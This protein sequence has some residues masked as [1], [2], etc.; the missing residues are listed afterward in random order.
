VGIVITEEFDP[1]GVAI[2]SAA[3][4][5]VIRD[6][7]HATPTR[8]TASGPGQPQSEVSVLL[9]QRSL[10][11]SFVPGAFV[12][13]GGAIDPADN[14]LASK[15][16]PNH[17]PTPAPNGLE[18][19]L[20][21]RAAKIASLRECFEEAGLLPGCH[22]NGTPLGAIPEKLRSQRKHVHAGVTPFSVALASAAIV[23]NLD[24]MIPFGRWVTPAGP[25]RR[26]DTRFFLVGAAEEQEA[27]EDGS[28]LVASQWMTPSSALAAA[29]A[30]ELLLIFPTRKTLERLRGVS[31][32]A[33]CLRNEGIASI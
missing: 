15:L 24:A 5:V 10:T 3:T 12:F 7:P 32:F 31:S 20:E 1:M 9:L 13:A 21:E 29:D 33:Q 27:S 14:E 11:A 28:E 4:L 17:L 25:P 8:S 18:A 19:V 2:R 23:P 26:F 6:A 16:F 30:G 22:I